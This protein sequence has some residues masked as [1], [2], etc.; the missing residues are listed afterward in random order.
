[1]SI[2]VITEARNDRK[3][4]I[5]LPPSDLKWVA[6]LKKQQLTPSNLKE[7][8]INFHRECVLRISSYELLTNMAKQGLFSSSQKKYTLDNNCQSIDF[9]VI[10]DLKRKSTI[11][12]TIRLR[13][14]FQ[15]ENNGYRLF[16][17]RI[18]YSLTDKNNDPNCLYSNGIKIPFRMEKV[19]VIRESPFY[20]NEEIINLFQKI[21]SINKFPVVRLVYKN[22]RK[23]NLEN[24]NWSHVPIVNRHKNIYKN[25]ITMGDYLVCQT[26]NALISY[27]RLSIKD[28][29]YLF[30]NL[31]SELKLNK[32]IVPLEIFNKFLAKFN[33][34]KK[35]NVHAFEIEYNR[36]S[37]RNEAVYLVRQILKYLEFW[38]EKFKY[39][40]FRKVKVDQP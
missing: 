33:Q 25:I 23:L 1:M 6:L 35:E 7:I 8:I 27:G 21:L 24:L 19:L 26:Q 34:Q 15:Q 18:I 30:N 36:P 37:V 11:P 17:T 32:K 12:I 20:I 29:K 2:A 28:N 13:L 22:Y 10:P 38:E 9:Y 39:Y 40:N 4:A 16:S 14:Y 3:K 31:L 5:Y